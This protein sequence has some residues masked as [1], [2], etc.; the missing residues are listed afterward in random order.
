[1]NERKQ[2]VLN[3][4]KRLFL[5]NGFANTSIQNILDEAGISKGT[6]YN[7]FN[8]KNECLISI[9]EESVEIAAVRRDEIAADG[10]DGPE[11]LVEQILVRL[12]MNREQKLI[13][14][15]EAILHSGDHELRDYMKSVHLSELAWLEQRLSEVYGEQ[16]RPYAADAAL[17]QFGMLGQ[18]LQFAPDIT[19]SE[20]LSKRIRF[21]IRRTEALLRDMTENDEHLLEAGKFDIRADS[22]PLPSPVRVAEEILRLADTLPPES[23]DSGLEFAGFLSAEL[24][25]EKPR[26]GLLK[27]V[28][29]PF[30]KLFDGRPNE[31]EARTVMSALWRILKSSDL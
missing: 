2:H 24:E 22:P 13:R 28:A 27:T 19:S 12:Q 10:Q 14:L 3:A 15:Y 31:P 21:V 7:Y 5:E 30:R 6:F 23:R 8:S 17:M 25:E 9:I 4:A 20:E 11:L 1:M 26:S 29:V 16:I 18:Y